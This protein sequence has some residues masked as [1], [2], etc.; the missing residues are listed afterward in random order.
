[1]GDSHKEISILHIS[2]GYV[3]YAL[4]HQREIIESKNK[5]KE[6]REEYLE[7]IPRIKNGRL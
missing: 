1:M 4:P 6:I 3:F 2:G 7:E 5:K